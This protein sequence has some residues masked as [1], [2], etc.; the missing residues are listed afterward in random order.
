MKSN[1]EIADMLNNNLADWVIDKLFN[2]YALLR[3]KNLRDMANQSLID[4]AQASDDAAKLRD[5]KK[6]YEGMTGEVC[7]NCGK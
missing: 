5:F 2:N 1:S 4:L 3:N 7:E 6:K